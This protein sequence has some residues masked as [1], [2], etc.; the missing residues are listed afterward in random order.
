MVLRELMKK[1]MGKQELMSLSKINAENSNNEKK[2]DLEAK[3]D[4]EKTEDVEMKTNNNEKKED[5]EMDK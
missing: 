4:D 3:K 2:E 5:V 1:E